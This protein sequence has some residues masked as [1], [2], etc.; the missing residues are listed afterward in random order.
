M[1]YFK[2]LLETFPITYNGIFHVES[3]YKNL[4]WTGIWTGLE[5]GLDWTGIWTGIWTGLASGL[6]WNLDWTGIWT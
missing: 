4:D 3:V 1:K 5:S 2:I 6:D